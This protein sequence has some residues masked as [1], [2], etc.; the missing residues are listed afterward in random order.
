MSL[1]IPTGILELYDD[2]IDDMINNEYGLPLF[3]D[4][5]AEWCMPCRKVAPIVKELEEDYRGKMLFAKLDIDNNQKTAG[6]YRVSS[7]PMFLIF[8]DG[9]L[10]DSS[11]GATGK[12]KFVKRI[13]KVLED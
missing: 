3:I 4:L 5:W 7:I 2:T 8:K 12:D 1:D 9:K 10:A 6:K 13:G 11:V